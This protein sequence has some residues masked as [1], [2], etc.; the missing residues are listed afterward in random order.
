MRRINFAEDVQN[1]SLD[2]FLEA[3]DCL[4]GVNFNRQGLRCDFSVNN[5]EQGQ[6][7]AIMVVVEHRIA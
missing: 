5:I 3:V 1:P 7:L 4:S 6:L 2:D